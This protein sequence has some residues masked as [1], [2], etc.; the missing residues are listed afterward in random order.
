MS[1]GK[2]LKYQLTKNE[3]GKLKTL[4][5][6]GQEFQIDFTGKLHNKKLNGE[7]QLLIAVDRFSKWPTVK[8]C[9]TSESKEVINFLK[10][11]FNLYGLPEKSNRTKAERLFQKTTLNSANRKILRLNIAHREYIPV[12]EQ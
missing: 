10:Q 11:N 5:E 7:N 2:N 4:T 1:S 9:K 6:P 3:S 8:I 12:R